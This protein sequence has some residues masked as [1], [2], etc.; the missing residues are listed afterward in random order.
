MTLIFLT[1]QVPNQKVKMRQF[2]SKSCH[3]WKPCATSAIQ[4]NN[5]KWMVEEVCQRSQWQMQGSQIYPRSILKVGPS[6]LHTVTT[7]TCNVGSHL[8]CGRD[9]Q[10]LSRC[11]SEG[12][13]WDSRGGHWDS[14]RSGGRYWSRSIVSVWWGCWRSVWPSSTP[15]EILSNVILNPRQTST[16]FEQ[17][18]WK[19]SAHFYDIPI[20]Y[21]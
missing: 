17:F 11:C 6:K 9:W 2:S 21:S 1:A 7:V 18:S 12:E 10:S 8:S 19:K 4:C 20:L 14:S 5:V 16:T 15:G 3:V 13:G